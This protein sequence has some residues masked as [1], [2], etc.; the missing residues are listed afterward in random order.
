[1]D[2]LKDLSVRVADAKEELLQ[3]AIYDAEGMIMDVCN[4]TSIPATMKNLQL[5]L[6]EIYARRMMAEGEVSR[7]EGDVSASNGYCKDI[8]EDLMKRILAKRKMKQAVVANAV[9][10]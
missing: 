9:K 6:A 8:P 3:Q 10:K 2:L 5:S 4:R 7:S 1:M